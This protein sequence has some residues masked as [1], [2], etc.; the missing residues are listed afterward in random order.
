MVRHTCHPKEA[1]MENI[2]FQL[3]WAKNKTPSQKYQSKKGW[4]RG[5]SDGVPA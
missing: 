2:M 1:E 3:A 5:S 4:R